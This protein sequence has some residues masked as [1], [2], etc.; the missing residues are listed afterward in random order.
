MNLWT[1]ILQVI[2]KPLMILRSFFLLY[3]VGNAK[4]EWNFQIEFWLLPACRAK[5]SPFRFSDI[6]ISIYTGG[7]YLDFWCNN[8]ISQTE[9]VI[10]LISLKRENQTK[11][12]KKPVIFDQKVQVKQTLEKFSQSWDLCFYSKKK[13]SKISLNLQQ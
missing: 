2:F 7:S 10:S 5:I 6:S 11:F 12:C 4:F 8:W 13:I 9:R 3:A 1:Q